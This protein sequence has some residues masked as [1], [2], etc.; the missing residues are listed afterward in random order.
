M[1]LFFCSKNNYSVLERWLI[2]NSVPSHWVVLNIDVGSS[3]EQIQ[4]GLE[5]CSKYG[6]IFHS[7]SKPE[8]QHCY[9]VAVKYCKKASFEWIIYMH[10][11]TYAFDP[12]FYYKIERKLKSLGFDSR[13]GFY[14]VNTYHDTSDILLKDNNFKWMTAARTFVQRSDGWYRR[15]L[16]C[17]VNFKNFKHEAFW[18]ESIHWPFAACHVNSFEVIKIDS[19]FQYLLAFDDM[20]FQMLLNNKCNIVLSHFDIAHDQSLK[21]GS[22]IQKK[23]TVASPDQVKKNFGRIDHVEMWKEKYGFRFIHRKSIYENLYSPLNRIA[24]R[25][26]RWTIPRFYSNLNTVIRQEFAANSIAKS[27]LLENFYHHDCYYGPIGYLNDDFM[28][29]KN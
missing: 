12:K 25:T 10:Q 16:G 6:L 1:L 13:A 23:S 19:R 24:S 29:F 27:T 5:L 7:A 18:S 14:G 8:F 21:E 17:R 28:K 22:G 3:A 20:L 15:M 4:K 11:D 9:S 2:N 26:T